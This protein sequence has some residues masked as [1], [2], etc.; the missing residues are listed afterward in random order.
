MLHH[1]GRTGSLSRYRQREDSVSAVFDSGVGQQRGRELEVFYVRFNIS[2]D[3]S[4][5]S[6]VL[7]VLQLHRSLDLESGLKKR[8]QVLKYPV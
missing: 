4:A 2:Q 3:L 7:T 5:G 6:K 8:L 1:L